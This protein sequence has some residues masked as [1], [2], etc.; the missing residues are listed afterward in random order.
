MEKD[1]ANFTDHGG[2]HIDQI[3]FARL[4][5]EKLAVDRGR[6]A[7]CIPLHLSGSRGA[8]FKV[9]L[10]SHGYTLV[11]KCVEEMDTALLNHETAIYDGIVEIQGKHVPVCWG[12][13]DL[14]LPYYYDYASSSASC[15][16]AMQGGL[17]SIAIR[18][19]WG[20]HKAGYLRPGPVASVSCK[21]QSSFPLS[22]SLL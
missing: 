4:I 19:T 8:L 10:S 20:R 22:F 13:I 14:V 12:T 2:V 15:S 5:R 7:D 1:C 11:A 3:Q 9:R 21:N 18:K 6:D 16:S 17:C